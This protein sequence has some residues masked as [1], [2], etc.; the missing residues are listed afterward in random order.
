ML[1]KDQTYNTVQGEV[2][3]EW[4]FPGATPSTSSLQNPS[5]TYDVSGQHD[6]ILK[7]S[8][9]NGS[10]ELVKE[11]YITVLE[12]ISSPLIEDFESVDFPSNAGLDKPNWY[13]LDEFPT[14]TN[15]KKNDFASFDGN[16]SIRIRSKD[17]SEGFDN[18]KQIIWLPEIDCSQAS[19]G[20]DFKLCF[21][22]SYAKRLPYT[23]LYGNS[24]IP[25]T[26]WIQTRR[27]YGIWINRP[28]PYNPLT[29]DDLVS[30]QNT[31][32]NN[33]VPIDSTDWKEICLDFNFARGSSS[34]MIKFEFQG[35]GYL[36]SDT[37]ITTNVGGEYISNNLGGNW[38]YI[39][40]VRIGSLQD[41]ENRIDITGEG[42]ELYNNRI[43]DLYGREYYEE[44]S[45]KNGIYFKNGQLVFI[46]GE[47]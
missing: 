24:V 26:L 5:V 9:N 1:F 34:L 35:K 44:H 33:Y 4:S 29:T 19:E 27:N 12:K 31:Y 18:V 10:V 42:D 17:Y 38:L 20:E 2:S 28:N 22:I 13:I 16:Q 11:N 46:K 15:W 7:V 47:L 43:F 40:N 25:D 3:Y 45:L 21:N 41:I 36:Q 23:D 6:V 14:E 8:N 32:F 30:N 39:D 37:L